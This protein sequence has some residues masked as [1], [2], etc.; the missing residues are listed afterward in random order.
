MTVFVYVNTSEQVGEADH[1]K[2]FVNL[3]AAETWLAGND[4]RGSPS[5]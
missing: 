4:P 3:D 5:I 2:I 1:L